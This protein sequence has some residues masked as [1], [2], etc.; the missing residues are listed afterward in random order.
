[1]PAEKKFWDQMMSLANPG[2]VVD[3]SDESVGTGLSRQEVVIYAIDTAS[4]WAYG[5]GLTEMAMTNAMEKVQAKRIDAAAASLAI[6][7]IARLGK[8]SAGRVD[9]PDAKLAV[10]ASMCALTSTALVRA[11]RGQTG[12]LRGHWLY[13]VYSTSNGTVFARSTYAERDEEGVIPLADL[14][15]LCA[16]V[17]SSDLA[18]TGGS[19]HRSIAEGGGLLLCKHLQTL[20]DGL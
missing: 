1:M 3:V 16:S 17:I 4:G 10:F 7:S 13:M 12:A 15:Q 14:Y 20:V 6:E 9:H 2:W 8:R 5:A 18:R 11:V 19:V